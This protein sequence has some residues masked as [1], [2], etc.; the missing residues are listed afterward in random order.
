MA[1]SAGIDIH[2][3]VESSILNHDWATCLEQYEG[4]TEQERQECLE[5][6]AALRNEFVKTLEAVTDDNERDVVFAVFYI[7]LKSQWMLFNVH[8]GYL[9]S[10]GKLDLRLMCRSGL[11]SAL[12]E[13]I[14]SAIPPDI[15]HAI[16]QFISQPTARPGE[17]DAY[18]VTALALDDPLADQIRALLQSSATEADSRENPRREQ[19]LIQVILKQQEML[20]NLRTERGIVEQRFGKISLHQMCDLFS[21][22]RHSL[23]SV[24]DKL[25]QQKAERQELCDALGISS[26]SLITVQHNALNAQVEALSAEVEKRRADEERL[27]QELGTSDVEEIIR[28][29][30]T[31]D[32]KS[33]V[34]DE[35]QEMLGSIES[36]FEYIN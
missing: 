27:V 9:I 5:P 14:E 18:P 28:R 19:E 22:M 20:Q 15:I 25:N 3:L 13:R 16:T 34:Y 23:T 32:S 4:A 33:S 30:K 12:L 11:V 35:L 6:V 7:L 17:I 2:N 36:S 29:L 21:N 24:V 8:S 10:A 1:F 31:D 26:F